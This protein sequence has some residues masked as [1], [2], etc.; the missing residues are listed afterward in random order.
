MLT[1]DERML[2]VGCDVDR[3]RMLSSAAGASLTIGH[4]AWSSRHGLYTDMEEVASSARR[5][6]N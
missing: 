4:G 5:L 2:G 3:G 1:Y 6:P